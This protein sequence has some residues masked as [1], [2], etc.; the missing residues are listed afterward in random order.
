MM[1]SALQHCTRAASP[2]DI[3]AFPRP[4]CVGRFYTGDDQMRDTHRCSL[5][6]TDAP[7]GSG[8]LCGE[9]THDPVSVGPAGSTGSLGD[10]PSSALTSE[11]FQGHPSQ[12]RW[13]HCNPG[14]AIL[15][16]LPI[17][18]DDPQRVDVL[19]W[20]GFRTPDTLRL[21]L[22]AGRHIARPRGRRDG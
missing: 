17:H 11:G 21:A 12:A 14:R 8:S 1:A 15:G 4:I 6:C 22:S 3:D 10:S 9:K 13:P 5:R 7:G 2:L 19:P 20:E 18:G 16:Y